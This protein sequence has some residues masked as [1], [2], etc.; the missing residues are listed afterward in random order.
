MKPK[1]KSIGKQVLKME[2]KPK[3]IGKTGARNEA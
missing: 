1:P 2:P 3:S